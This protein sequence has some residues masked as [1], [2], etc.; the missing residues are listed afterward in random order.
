MNHKERKSTR[1]HN[2]THPKKEKERRKV[3]RTRSSNSG[4]WMGVNVVLHLKHLLI[5][6]DKFKYNMF[7]ILNDIYDP[8]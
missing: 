3:A 2:H 4:V 8:W 1:T 6:P 7:L 5:F